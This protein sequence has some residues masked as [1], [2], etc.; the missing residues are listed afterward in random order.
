M[1][2]VMRILRWSDGVKRDECESKA[3]SQSMFQWP[4]ALGSDQNNVLMVP[5]LGPW[6]LGFCLFSI[7]WFVYWFNFH[8]SAY[9]Y[10]F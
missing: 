5:S 8:P 6:V 9:S 10:I 3:V 2:S 4:R 1:F 7:L